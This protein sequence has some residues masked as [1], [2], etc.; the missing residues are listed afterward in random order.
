MEGT[1]APFVRKA[2]GV[3]TTLLEVFNEKLDLPKGALASKHT[4]E[5]HSGSEAR[6]I[7]KQPSVTPEDGARPIAA[8]GGHTDFGS[9]VSICSL[10]RGTNGANLARSSHSCTTDSVVCKCSFQTRTSGSTLS[11]CLVMQSATSAMHSP[12]LVVGSYALT[13]TALCKWLWTPPMHEQ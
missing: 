11:L 3:N 10:F 2:L 9:L 6:T 7:L 8:I 4:L 1:I 12:S 5:E 13:C